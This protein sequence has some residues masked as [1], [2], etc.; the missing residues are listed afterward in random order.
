MNYNTITTSNG[1][2]WNIESVETCLSFTSLHQETFKTNI[3]ITNK[4][5]FNDDIWD[6]NETNKISKE[7]NEYKF[8][9]S[10]IN[11]PY[12]YYAKIITLNSLFLTGHHSS[13]SAKNKF[14]A[15]R[16]FFIWLYNKKIFALEFIDIDLL[17]EYFN[18]F[19][20]KERTIAQK[21]A[22][23]KEFFIELT[24]LFPNSDFI[25]EYTF[26]DQYDRDRVLQEKENNKYKLI[27]YDSIDGTASLFDTIISLALSDIKNNCLPIL[28][29]KIAC[30]IVILAETGMRIGE[31]DKLEVEKLIAIEVPNNK[32]KEYYLEFLTYK[33]SPSPCGHWT[34]TYMTP[35]AVLAYNT[36]IKLTKVARKLSN[37]KY[38]YITS[39]TG[40]KYA[41]LSSLWVHNLYFYLTHQS[42]F[43]F[44]KMPLNIL[45]TFKSTNF[46]NSKFCHFKKSSYKEN[47]DSIIY[48]ITPHQYR[49]TVATILYVKKHFSLEWIRIHMNHMSEEMTQHYIRDEAFKKRKINIVETLIKRASKDGNILE[50]DPTKIIN[51]NIKKELEDNTLKNAYTEI[52]NFLESLRLRKK[53]LNIYKDINEIIEEIFK[54]QLPLSENHLGFCAA[55]VLLVLCEHQEHF[56]IMETS[57]ELGLHV[58]TID[59]LSDDI[60]R[61]K[62]KSEIIKH[63]KSLFAEDDIYAEIYEK[64][65]SKLKYFLE[66]RLIPELSL[67]D[68]EI[69]NHG[70]DIITTRYKNILPSLETISIIKGEIEKWMKY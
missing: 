17:I 62:E 16:H 31:F 44:H 37:S 12:K 24:K 22:Y 32:H 5:N 52:N 66:N 67:L 36:L 50:T 51:S 39:K 64:E 61:F 59:T 57:Y 33:T 4:C 47:S 56:N 43:N 55:D 1:I 23:I 38:L 35:N 25:E 60:K 21:K 49:V 27:Q 3:P 41:Q 65:I 68:S 54:K 10:N 63:N 29:R 53:D 46:N 30:M 6:F 34:V 26:L 13:S 9:F 7:S 28:Q 58:P 8:D 18:E 45:N 20:L 40:T 42:D 69:Q 14:I 2:E 11:S 15:L 70:L 19:K 48:Y